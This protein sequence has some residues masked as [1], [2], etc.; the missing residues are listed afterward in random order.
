MKK[1]SR[2][3]TLSCAAFFLL[4]LLCL[5]QA[6]AHAA[7][8]IVATDG[9]GDYNCNGSNDE[10][11][12]NLALSDIAATG[13]TVHLQA[14]TYVIS[15]PIAIA[16]NNTTLEG[17]GIEQTTIKLVDEANWGGVVGEGDTAN[18]LEAEPL[19]ANKEG[20]LHHL[21]IRNLKIDG[22]KYNQHYTHPTRG[23]IHVPDGHGNYD[24]INFAPRNSVERLHDILLSHVYVYENS[25]DAF[26]VFN[27]D[28]ITVE[29]CKTLR[30]G[31]SAIYFLDPLRCLAEHN[32]FTIA[33]NSGIRWYD[34]NHII[35]RNNFIQGDPGKDGSS[36]FCIQVTSGQTSRVLD[37]LLIENN[38]MRYTAGAAIALDAKNPAKAKGVII[39]NNSIYQCGNVGTWVN[40]R[41]TGGINIK[42]FT[43]TLIEN[44]TIV[45][46]IGGG[47]RLGGNVGFNDA[48]DE[49]KGLTAVIRNNII[50]NT[51]HDDTVIAEIPAY[52]IEVADGNTAH[53]TY[54]NVWNNH[55]GNY[56]GTEPDVGSLSVD[57]GFYDVDLGTNF[58]NT[59]GTADFHLQS[60]TGRWNNTLSSWETDS[61]SSLC[62]N[63]GDPDTA[64]DREP[65]PNGS[66]VNMGVYGNTPVASKGEKA[67][68]VA[69]AGPDQVQRENG[70][71]IVYVDLDG[72]GSSDNGTISSYVW[73]KDGITLAEGEMPAAVPMMIGI[74]TITLTVT[75]DDQTSTTDSVVIRVNRH[76]QNIQPIAEAGADQTVTDSDSNNNESVLLDGR[77]SFDPDGIITS[78]TWKDE[79]D[80]VLATVANPTLNFPVGIHTLTLTVTDTENGT[81]SD[82]V[83]IEVRS[84]NDYALNFNSG[85]I[86]EIVQ[87]ESIPM[88][89]SNLT[90]EMWVKQS[91]ST[92]D[93]DSLLNF[94]EDGQRLVLTTPD[95]LPSWGEDM[96]NHATAGFSM[97]QW[98]H[99]AFV[100]ENSLLAAIY[101]DGSAQNLVNDDT[102]LMPD[103]RFAIASFYDSGASEHNFKGSID[104]L[105]LWNVARTAAEISANY[106]SELTPATEE[107]LVGYWDFNEGSGDKLIDKAGTSDGTL[108]NMDP[109]DWVLGAIHPTGTLSYRLTVINGPGDGAYEAGATINLTADNPPD[110]YHFDHWA[111][112]G[113]GSFADT[114]SPATIF[115][116]PAHGVTVTANFIENAPADDDG[117]T[118]A[119][120]DDNCP[121][122]ANTD[123]ADNDTDG[124]GD[125][126]D[127]DDDNDG[128]PDAWEDSHGL[129]ARDASDR[130]LDPDEDGFTNFQEYQQGTDPNIA[131][132]DASS[133]FF[134]IKTAGGKVIII[135]F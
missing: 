127:P 88:P 42:N 107:H 113:G 126:C 94:G 51:I 23:R 109:E 77:T 84:Q 114:N 62:I 21:T 76:G 102:I 117:D 47:I 24:A 80:N 26:I 124:I 64:F 48:W 125:V 78:Y 92:E 25:S 43:D 45:N 133:L 27:G 75:D 14:G 32:H 81:G 4:T 68:P 37:D 118:I 119:N 50:T 52:G 33:A 20:A 70:S 104:E 35:V 11:E 31:H 93:T 58:S 112:S 95:R 121:A 49:I 123:Q 135:H 57:P 63:A 18:Y 17:D 72:S 28:D 60:E 110:G 19:I 12:I 85:S 83:H 91:E 44:N 7:T 41:E 69:S 98:H 73:N 71:G 67:P 120:E 97:K 9:S 30:I 29:Y 132:S 59:N 131:N 106:N 38:E 111:S 22:N 5:S 116:M 10:I 99:L 66:R 100:V 53:C 82:T 134:P 13:G 89:S 8:R 1:T 34:G 65:V 74:H 15:N 55:S 130:D 90:I 96:T 103:A 36:N 129:N 40:Q 61:G 101:I 87:I 115:T 2:N 86:D 122:Q 108:M 54:N 46:N 105:R 56:H 3:Y 128:M 39:R 6:T 79:Q 16:G